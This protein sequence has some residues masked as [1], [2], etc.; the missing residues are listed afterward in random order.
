MN[1]EYTPG[2]VENVL[3]E[4]GI[5]V[6]GETDTNLLC[7]CVYHRNQDT[8]ALSVDK[9]KGVFLCFSPSCDQRGTLLQLVQD[10]TR[11]NVFGAKRLIEK[12]RGSEPPLSSYI[13]TMFEQNDEIPEFRQDVINRLS[14]SLWG[15]PGQK[16]MNGRGFTDKTLS[17]F[18]IGYSAKNNMVTIPVHDAAGRPVGMVGRTIEGKRFKNTDNLPSRRVLFNTHRAKRHGEKVILVES[19]MDAMRIHQAGFPYV[20]ATNG[21]IFSQ[22]HVQAIDKYF[23]EVIIMTDMDDP[24]D[25]RS[26]HCKKCE[27]TCLGHSPGRALGDKIERALPN[28]RI[29]WATYDYG[30]V[31]PHGAKDA[32]DMTEEEIRQCIDNAVTGIEYEMWKHSFPI[33]NM[34]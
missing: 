16:Y 31:Y 14:D 13:D 25:H 26:V 9:D 7:L 23:N 29:R 10:V 6:M 18:V 20:V 32:G 8:P 30:I 22:Y 12:Y 33:L 34:I 5:S 2:Q 24:D 17:E 15:S 3:N 1:E 4:I 27:N 28:K 19:S 21:S 11:K